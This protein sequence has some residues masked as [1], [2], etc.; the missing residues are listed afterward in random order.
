M[1]TT[2]ITP[3]AFL[4]RQFSLTE[5]P[6]NNMVKPV[7]KRPQKNSHR[8]AELNKPVARRPMETWTKLKASKHARNTVNPIRKIADAMAV[9]PNP[10]K[11]AIKLNLGD[12]TIMGNLPPSQASIDAVRE[13]L[14]SH[15]ADGYGPSVGSMP[16]RQAIADTFSTPSAPINPDDVILA[17]GCSH[18][19][20][21]ALEAIADN[22]DNVLVPHPGFPLYTTLCTPHGIGTIGYQLRMNDD[23]LIDLDDLESKI[24][25]KTRA[26]I[27]NNPSN[28]T[29]IVFPKEHLEDILRLAEK[30]RLTIIADE[31]YGDLTYDDEVEF[32]PMASLSPQVPIISCDG[33]G[34][35]FLV[36]GWRLGWAIV[37]NRH[38]VLTDVRAGMVALSQKIVGP[39]SLIQAALPKILK[40]TPKSYFDNI[41]AVVKL[42]ADI[43]YD[44][45]RQI[46]YLHP[47]RPQGA[48]YM[49]VRIDEN[50]L[51]SETELIQ[52][53]IR[54]ESV[55]CLPG[56][57]FNCPGWFRLVLTYPAEITRDACQR[58]S[59]YCSAKIRGETPEL[60]SLSSDEYPTSCS[61]ESNEE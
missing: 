9:A 13:A 23:G 54:H 61:S 51:G 40:N 26:I 25:Q 56:S 31:I 53:L 32:I 27:I 39:C 7:H 49:M 30:Y 5:T 52:E 35:R 19:L 8:V 36:P 55:Y 1:A 15:T 47:L 18:A 10:D 59:K 58:I 24:N 22:G 14:E 57:A 2:A 41:R 48:L 29:G 3:N 38:N 33:I 34:K 43:C 37:Y 44:T 46:P 17:S 4:P 11:Y 50:Y 20:Q 6:R 42:N 21:M 12:P 60:P 45:F 28:P 16:A